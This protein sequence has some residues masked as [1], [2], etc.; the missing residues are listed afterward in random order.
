MRRLIVMRHGEAEIND[1]ISDHDRPL[2]PYGMIQADIVAQKLLHIGHLP[3]LG[4]VSSA[5]R[6]RETQSQLARVLAV[7]EW[8][9]TNNL[10]LA[11]VRSLVRELAQVPATIH[12]VIVVGHNPGLSDILLAL[13]DQALRLD[14]A[15]AALLSIEADD[16]DEAM[17]QEGQW[18]L[19][20]HL[21]ATPEHA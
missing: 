2:T 18:S 21:S 6:T 4:L 17:A 7:A 10:Y 12:S 1:A 9:T 14:T 5:R 8:Q 3:Q 11:D 13:A 20:R 15:E 16:W 19:L